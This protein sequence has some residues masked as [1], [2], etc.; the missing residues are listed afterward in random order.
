MTIRPGDSVRCA[1]TGTIFTVGDRVIMREPYIHQ[2]G[3]IGT[4]IGFGHGDSCIRVQ[5]D[6]LRT[7]T[8]FHTKFWRKL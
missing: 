7:A 1:E 2:V 3:R 6:G 4:V 8:T 5:R